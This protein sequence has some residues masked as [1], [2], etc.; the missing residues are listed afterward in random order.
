MGELLSYREQ[1]I[2]A[3]PAVESV[4]KSAPS[5]GGS[6]RAS[7]VVDLFRRAELCVRRIHALGGV[8]KDINQ[9]LV[10]FP[11]L[12]DG[13]EVFLCWK[14]GEESI[15]FWHDTESGFAGRKPL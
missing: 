12:R 13:R 8:L 4:L 3:R 1:I 14:H 5:N 15:S 10:D 6:L 11:S 9:G 2:A 7:E